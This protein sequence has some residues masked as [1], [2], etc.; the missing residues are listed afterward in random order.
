VTSSHRRRLAPDGD[1]ARRVVDE[2]GSAE[3]VVAT[4]L[5]LLLILL[6]IQFALFEHA[7]QVAQT[8]AAEAL[9]A[10]R[11]DGATMSSGQT[12]AQVI[13]HTVGTGVL[14]NPAVSVTRSATQATVTVTGTTEA[15]VPFL[16]M[17]VH[18]TSSGPVERFVAGP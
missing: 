3:L 6:V 17:P 5:L 4:P 7:S 15:V 1:G 16:H 8:A 9:A 10:T 12:E 11:T 13:L 18:A 2:R 14:L